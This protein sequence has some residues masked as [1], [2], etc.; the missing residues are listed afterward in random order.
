MTT[1]NIGGFMKKH[2][3]KGKDDIATFIS[4]KVISGDTFMINR[5]RVLLETAVVV[6]ATCY[7]RG[8]GMDVTTIHVQSTRAG[9]IVREGASLYLSDMTIVVENQANALSVDGDAFGGL[10]LENVRVI[11]ANEYAT[12]EKY[13]LVVVGSPTKVQGKFLNAARISM[14]NCEIDS[15]MINAHH[16]TMKDTVLSDSMMGYQS[17]LSFHELVSESIALGGTVLRSYNPEPVV[18]GNMAIYNGVILQGHFVV[19]QLDILAPPEVDENQQKATRKAVRGGLIQPTV[20][21]LQVSGLDNLPTSAVLMD[22]ETD[23]AFDSMPTDSSFRTGW[24]FFHQAKLTLKG[25]EIGASQSGSVLQSCDILLDEME[26]RESWQYQDTA[27]DA[28]L[29]E[30]SLPVGTQRTSGSATHSEASSGQG[31]SK[32]KDALS[33]LDELTGLANV[34]RVIHETV[35]MASM[36]M[37]R[38]QRG[39]KATSGMSLHTIFA[40]SAGTGKTTVARQYGQALYEKG[41]LRSNRFVEATRKDLVA[42]YIGQ[43]SEKA[44]KVVESA[45]GGVL[46]IDE[47]YTLMPSG[48][49]DFADEAVAQ[50][51]ADMENHRDDLVVILAGYTDEMRDFI[52]NG[53]PGLKSRFTNWVTFEDYTAEELVEIMGYQLNSQQVY[54]FD[55]V[56]AMDVRQSLADVYN[57]HM[58]EDPASVGNGRFVR[59]YVQA[60]LMAKDLRIANSG[61]FDTMSDEELAMFTSDDV[62]QAAKALYAKQEAL[63]TDI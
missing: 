33:A 30:T 27:I 58:Y 4:N 14:I 1:Y 34:K 40:G 3:H 15:A 7:I 19:E 13:P 41:V 38:K 60:L 52:N 59:N 23:D 62:E 37:V 25:F 61:A 17:M 29:S 36:N 20:F 48:A 51:I 8:Q 9:F 50:L 10:Y 24:F 57:H 26:D 22:V 5:K 63:R 54:P 35:S 16:I 55:D 18:I 32:P 12:Q 56:A 6:P 28:R 39:M 31:Q 42:G 46:F 43:T 45:L 53:N 11:Y 47:A 44:H 2:V 49:N 21:A